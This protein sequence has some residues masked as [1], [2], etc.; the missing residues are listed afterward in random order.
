MSIDSTSARFKVLAARAAGLWSEVEELRLCQ[1]EGG[2]SE[3]VAEVCALALRDVQDR[4]LAEA[5]QLEKWERIEEEGPCVACETLH[6]P[7]EE[8]PGEVR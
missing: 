5:I 4:L 6:E 1:P 2:T 7:Y 8:C 3:A